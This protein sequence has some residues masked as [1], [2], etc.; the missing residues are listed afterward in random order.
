MEKY[1][2]MLNSEFTFTHI[3][4]NPR[5]IPCMC[6]WKFQC[7]SRLESSLYLQTQKMWESQNCKQTVKQKCIRTE[8]SACPACPA[9]P[10]CPACPACPTCPACL[11]CPTIYLIGTFIR[12]QILIVSDYTKEKYWIIYAKFGGGPGENPFSLGADLVSGSAPGVC[13]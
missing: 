9:C 3:W 6:S 13:E 2:F 11:A 12:E 1:V 4:R 5:T 7:S 10:T 8:A